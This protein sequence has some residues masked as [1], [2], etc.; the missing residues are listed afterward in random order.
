MFRLKLREAIKG[1]IKEK[2]RNIES[3]D[4]SVEVPEN[5]AHGDYATN[6]AM[7]LAKV[8]KKPPMAIAEAIARGLGSPSTGS[9]DNGSPS[10]SSGH[11]T[12]V[13][14]VAPG[15]INF[16]VSDEALLQALQDVVAHPEKWGKSDVG[17]SK[18]VIVEYFQLNIAKRPHVGHLRSAVIGD[19]LKRMLRAEGYNAISDTHVG[20]WGTQFGI[21]LL[22]YREEG[23]PAINEQDPFDELE[24]IYQRGAQRAEADTEWRE[25]AKGEFAKLEKGDTER[26]KIWQWMVDVSMKKLEESAE[27]L[28]LLP[29]DEHRG[30]SAYED[31]MPPIIDEAL[32]KGVA[33]KNEDGSVVVDLSEDALDEAVLIK[34]DG[35]TTYLLR[36][37]AALKYRTS[38]HEFFENLYVVDVRQTHHFRQVFRVAELL[39]WRGVSGS[40]HIA[41]GFMTLPEGPMSTRKGTA[42]SLDAVLDEAERRARAIIQEK[43]PELANREEVA[44]M[45]GLGAL[46]YFD[47]S[48]NRKSDIV[49]DWDRALAF[50]G[51]TGPYLQYTHARLRSILRKVNPSTSSGNISGEKSTRGNISRA[52]S[53]DNLQ[54]SELDP[55][56][57]HIAASIL[58]FP[59]AIE[60]TLK[61]Y[62]PNV[63]VNYLYHL[64]QVANEFYHSHPVMQ[65]EDAKK[66]A[67]RVALVSAAAT[68]LKNG[69][70]LL[71]I[72]APEEM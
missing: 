3:P 59:E 5:S 46:K 56:E 64:A 39:G 15:F 35:A 60:D 66:R 48:H 14:V 52:K 40:R 4:F 31:A 30:E 27:R 70:G 42:I 57:H 71:G 36:D 44:Q 2:F 17:K 51:N 19:A 23:E 38:H 72:E 10:T 65:E 1:A 54:A 41:F 63:L 13:E 47:L 26:R 58:R 33:K 28:G 62:F 67:V 43:N 34:S 8:L 45:V 68:T 24:K 21:L 69:L 61:E 18:K 12:R 37:L 32:Q 49:F 6:V 16:T 25:K 11:I 29:F 55:L 20:D 50:E 7:V 53:R 9:G 22:Q